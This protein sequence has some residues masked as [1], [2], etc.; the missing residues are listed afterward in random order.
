MNLFLKS[1][2]FSNLEDPGQELQSIWQTPR[3]SHGKCQEGRK[4]AG[5]ERHMAEKW[6]LG[7]LRPLSCVLLIHL[8]SFY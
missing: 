1:Q 7:N 2:V 5:M 8:K 3:L 4:G 6:H